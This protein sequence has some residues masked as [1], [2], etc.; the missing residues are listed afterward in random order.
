MDA[1]ITVNEQQRIVL[2][3]HQARIGRIVVALGL[4][5]DKSR[6]DIQQINARGEHAHRNAE[7]PLGFDLVAVFREIVANVRGDLRG[8]LHA[9]GHLAIE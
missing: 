6:E 5:A 9:D 7:F 8:A 1:I 4:G 3:D 2:R